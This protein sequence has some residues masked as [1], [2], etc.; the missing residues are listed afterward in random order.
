MEWSH[1]MSNGLQVK[2]MFMITIIIIKNIKLGE[3]SEAIL[4][5]IS[6]FFYQTPECPKLQPIKDN[7]LQKFLDSRR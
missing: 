7:H 3:A 6:F 5:R 1:S 4:I 2:Y